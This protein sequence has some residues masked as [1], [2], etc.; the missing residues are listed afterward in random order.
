MNTIIVGMNII[1]ALTYHRSPHVFYF[2]WTAR[3]IFRVPPWS[4]PAPA[5]ILQCGVIFLGAWVGLHFDMFLTGF[6][7]YHP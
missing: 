4:D 5:S 6:A 7:S 2:L 1:P 3:D